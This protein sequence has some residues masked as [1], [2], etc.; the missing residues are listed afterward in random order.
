MRTILVNFLA[1]YSTVA[2]LVAGRLDVAIIQFP[3]QKAAAELESALAK[4]NLFE[5]T[6]ADR[7]RTTHPYLKAGYVLFGQRLPVSPGLNFWTTTRLK[8]ASAGVEGRLETGRVSISISL[9]EGVKA[10]LRT[11]QKKVYTGA[12][13]LPPGP[14]RLLAIRQVSGRFPSIVKGHAKMESYHQTTVVVAQYAP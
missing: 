9:M 2:S 7:T 14:P 5:M 1:A 12:G 8:N 11:F 3:E 6:N 13:P 10:G 4:V